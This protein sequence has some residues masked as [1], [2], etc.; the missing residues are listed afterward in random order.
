MNL[1]KLEKKLKDQ[2]STTIY[3]E[4][5]PDCLKVC[6]T[7]ATWEEVLKACFQCVGKIKG[8]RVVNLLECKEANH[9]KMRSSNKSDH[10][11]DGSKPDVLI[12]G[13]GISGASI[14]RELTRWKVSV[15]LLEKES[16]LA[17]QASGRNDGEV[18]PGVDLKKG[19]LK[20]KYVV[21][22]NRMFDQIC[23]DL[24][25]PFERRGQYVGFTNRKLKPILHLY[26]MEKRIRCKVTDTRIIGRTELFQKEPGL[27]PDFQFAL[28]NPTAGCV[29]PYNLTIA[30]AENAVANGA[31][32]H[33]NTTV[34]GMKVKNGAIREVMTNRGTIY[35]KIVINAAGVFAEE[36]AKMAGDHCYS[37]HPRRGTNSILDKKI[38]TGVQSIASIK[39]LHAKSNHSK[40][41]GILRTVHHNLL[42]GPDAVETYEKENFATNLDSIERVFSKQQKTDPNLNRNDIITYFTGV[43]AATFEEDFVIEFGHRTK[44]LIHC[45]GIQSPGL[46]TAPAVAVDIAQMTVK[47]LRKEIL[48]RENERFNPK[49]Q[50][51][52]HV[53]ALPMNERDALI[54]QNPDYGLMICRCE[55]V[56]KGEIL[57]A[58]NAPISVLTVDG[59]KRRVRPGMGRCQGGF[60]MPLIME[61]I[62]EYAQIPMSDV[63]KG[64]EGSIL[65]YGSSREVRK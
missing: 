62:S 12:I 18:H 17:M 55:E 33:L 22:G 53:S 1:Q 50:G 58:L 42:V 43:R 28:Y 13:G 63:R 52:P 51:I 16:D 61:I 49:R 30:Y 65:S 6:G 3:L 36:I 19:S 56:S 59:I 48:I 57:D 9:Q 10:S 44:N 26:A 20:Q 39:E 11:L 46:T 29:C 31:A 35:P 7:V 24:Q 25:V 32:V 27:N 40:G 60:C 34:L 47:F 38:V 54:K 14:A 45:A 23:E 4:E 41:G 37:I 15:M 8:K 5:E 64:S 21:R 2:I